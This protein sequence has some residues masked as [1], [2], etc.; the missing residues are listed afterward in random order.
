VPRL[1]G[2]ERGAAAAQDSPLAGSELPSPLAPPPGCHYHPRCPRAT[3]ICRQQY[4]A[5][6]KSGAGR[7][8]SCHWPLD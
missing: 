1:P 4:P 8:V 5:P 7:W 2:E 6:S 3:D